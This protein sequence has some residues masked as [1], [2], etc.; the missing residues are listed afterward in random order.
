MS[1]GVRLRRAPSDVAEVLLACVRDPED[2]HSPERIAGLVE[3]AR[4]GTFLGLADRH[5]VLGSVAR[6]LRLAPGVP[7]EDVAAVEGR[8]ARQAARHLRVLEELRAVADVLDGFRWFVA[9][10]PVLAETVYPAPELRAYGDLDLF[11]EPARFA[12]ALTALEGA[13]AR[14][15]DQNW[16]LLR[17]D[18]RGQVH[19]RLPLGTLADVHWHVINRGAVR[20]LFRL[21]MGELF[22]RAGVADLAGVRVPVL[23][24]T[25]GLLHLALHAALSGC[26]RL[27]WL[28]DVAMTLRHGDVD[29]VEVVRR[30][31]AWGIGPSVAIVLD[32]TAAAL[33]VR[34]DPEVLCGLDGSR[35]R[36]AISRTLARAWP[37]ERSI[38]QD[39]G[40]L[41][42]ELVRDSWGATL[43]ATW[44]RA[45]RAAGGPPGPGGHASLQPA[46]GPGERRAFLASVAAES[47][48]R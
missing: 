22:E 44:R 2:P 7:G 38:G 31:R 43:V 15:E 42:T 12:E 30:A 33:G 19:V 16:T 14:I 35:T 45:L 9:K 37:P 25:D 48:D 26:N 32:R 29:G 8:L 46:G 11:V 39:P 4:L 3:R 40:A 36:R 34:I 20:D 21:P 10:G 24:P 6:P 28:Q 27:V 1:R 41:W 17:R 13:G 47:A 18:R 23:E 5:R